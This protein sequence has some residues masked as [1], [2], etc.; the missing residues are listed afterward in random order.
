MADALYRAYLWETPSIT[1]STV[2][3]GFE[4]VLVESPAL[5]GLMAEPEAFAGPIETAG[6]GADVAAFARTAP[7]VRQQAFWRV[8][9]AAASDRLS[10]RSLWLS[11]NDLGV[12]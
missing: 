9:G 1:R 8:V 4:F 7:A 12:A 2:T 3:Q 10:D 6:A 5:A 11:T